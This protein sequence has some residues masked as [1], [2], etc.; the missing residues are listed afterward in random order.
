VFGLKHPTTTRKDLTA[1][2]TESNLA[3]CFEGGMDRRQLLF[4]ATA[5]GLVTNLNLNHLLIAQVGKATMGGGGLSD[6]EQAGLRGQVKTC[7]DFFGERADPICNTEY[8]TDGRLLGWRFLSSHSSGGSR[9]EHVYSYERVYSYDEMGRLIGITGRSG[10]TYE[11][12]DEKGKKALVPT[13]PPRADVTDDYRYDEKGKKTRVRTVPPRPDQLGFTVIFDSKMLEV[14]EEGRSLSGGG[15]VTTRY[16]GDDQPIESL[17][18]DA[19]EELLTQIFHNYTNGR[20]ISETL[21]IVRENFEATRQMRE[22]F[23][24]EQQRANIAKNRAFLGQLQGLRMGRSYA[25]DDDDRVIR[26]LTQMG[27]FKQDDSMT[28]NEQGDE[29]WT[30]MIRNGVDDERSEFRYLYQYDS[31]GNWT[32]RTTINTD[33]PGDPSTQRRALAYY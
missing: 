4:G 1:L 6:R 22:R 10:E 24:D 13:V 5:L 26:R 33:R 19:N 7:S 30:V 14:T 11:V 25:Y 3:E 16:N 15:T 32:E 20:L 18:H 17:V 21:V 8:G 28:Y 29:A 2:V 23:S 31:H 12:Y 9:V 27:N